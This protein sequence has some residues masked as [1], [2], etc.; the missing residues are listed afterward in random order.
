MIEIKRATLDKDTVEQL[1]KLSY[2]WEEEDI[3]FGLHHNTESN[4]KEPCY[5][6]LD[7]NEIVGYIFGHY[8]DNEKVVSNDEGGIPIGEKCFDID[9]IYIK[10][11]YRNQGIGKKLFDKLEEEVKH[12][13]KWLTLPTSTKDYKK[14]L[15]FYSEVI[16]MTFHS[17]FLFKKC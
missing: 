8:Y 17:A 6:A 5:I 2:L 11:E 3:T 12:N 14:I 10:K 15:H 9:E 7:N 4:L 13:C 16:G 1:I